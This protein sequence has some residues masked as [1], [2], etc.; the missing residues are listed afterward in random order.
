[1]EQEDEESFEMDDDAVF[2]LIDLDEET[3]RLR[4][5]S[6]KSS[7]SIALWGLLCVLGIY[8]IVYQMVEGAKSGAAGSLVLGLGIA[9]V[10]LSTRSAAGWRRRYLSAKADG[11]RFARVT[12]KPDRGLVERPPPAVHLTFDDG[13]E[14]VLRSTTWTFRSCRRYR[15]SPGAKVWV[16]GEGEDFVV[17]FSEG[18][19]APVPY[20]FPARPEFPSETT[21]RETGRR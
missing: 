4:G 7:W 3:E 17:L 16:A 8:G 10:I 15:E 1:M 5:L 13:T 11:W 20:A 6:V 18:W 21:S 19:V 2:D 14:T 9:G 12:V